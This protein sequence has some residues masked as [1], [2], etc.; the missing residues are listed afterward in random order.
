MLVSKKS[1]LV[2]VC[3]LSISLLTP[4]FSQPDKDVD[5]WILMDQLR[6]QMAILHTVRSDYDVKRTGD[7]KRT[8]SVEMSYLKSH[9]K[10]NI[11]SLT[12]STGDTKR[13][14]RMVYN[15]E[16]LKTYRHDVT[17][18]TRQHGAVRSSNYD[19]WISEN[20]LLRM[21]GYA[22]V[23]REPDHYVEK[24]KKGLHKYEYIGTEQIDGLMCH[25]ICII[26]PYRGEQ[27]GYNYYW[28]YRSPDNKSLK[29]M[30]YNTLIDNDPD[31]LLMERRFHYANTTD[32]GIPFPSTME[33]DQYT[34]DDEGVRKLKFSKRIQVKKL[35][36]N[37]EV[38]DSEFE[39]TFPQGTHVQDFIGRIN[40]VMGGGVDN[41]DDRLRELTVK[42]LEMVHSNTSTESA[43][44]GMGDVEVVN[45]QEDDENTPRNDIEKRPE[46]KFTVVRILLI[47]IALSVAYS[48]YFL[49]RKK[50]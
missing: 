27:Y 46:Q 50:S 19:S 26:S 24:Y 3:A 4:A 18:A 32:D 9:K 48:M 11:K 7:D 17:A 29:I 37:K 25:K 30:K 22:I 39:F 33:Y 23:A 40:Y 16:V 1:K 21:A 41:I 49:F 36:I 45:Q 38:K 31:S 34:I 5:P 20:D 13:E 15:E 6:T 10:F 43:K 35:E 8:Y 2:I 14:N 47:I 28:I 42:D 44:L 12:Q